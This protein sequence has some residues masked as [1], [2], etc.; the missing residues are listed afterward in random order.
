MCMCMCTCVYACNV[1]VFMEHICIAGG[2]FIIMCP[3]GVAHGFHVICKAEGR[4]DAFTLLVTRWPASLGPL[5]VIYDFA[6]Q[7]ME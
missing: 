5:I 1:C 4:N 6:C 7:L 3:H 2:I